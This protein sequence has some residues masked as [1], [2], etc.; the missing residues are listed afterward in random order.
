MV[1]HFRQFSGSDLRVHSWISPI[2]G[3]KSTKGYGSG[4][5]IQ[6]RLTMDLE[7]S[8]LAWR[9]GEW[10]ARGSLWCYV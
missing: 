10:L 2:V 1:P 9:S 7:F 4:C 3:H 8:H 5:E 6:T